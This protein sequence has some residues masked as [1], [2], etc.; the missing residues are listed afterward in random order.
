VNKRSRFKTL[1]AYV[2]AQPRLKSQ[3]DIAR[4]LGISPSALS[5]YLSGVRMPGREVALRISAKC[6]IPLENLLTPEAKAS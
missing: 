2:E 6:G 3:N 4:E 5:S 1:R